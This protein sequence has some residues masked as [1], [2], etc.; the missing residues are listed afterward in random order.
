MITLQILLEVKKSFYSTGAILRENKVLTTLRLRLCGLG[1]SG[2]C[3]VF[4]AVR[5][6]TT[7]AKLDL[8]ET[9]FDDQSIASLGKYNP[10]PPPAHCVFV[11]SI[12]M[13]ATPISL[14][15]SH[16]PSPLPTINCL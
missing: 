1:P 2:L 5:V 13:Y 15:Q 3:E 12:V 7:L 4:D 8:T 16:P 9:T 6:N 14:I 11:V 10:P